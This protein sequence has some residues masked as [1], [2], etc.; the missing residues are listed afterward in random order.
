LAFT[1]QEKEKM[2]SR[3]TEWLDKSQAI[4]LLE[5]HGMRMKDM[6]TLRA[7]VRDAGGEVHVVKNT[8]LSRAMQ[9]AGIKY[10]E[11]VFDGP[12]AISF[13]YSD[14]PGLAKILS[15][16]TVKSEIFKI[17]GG[18]LGKQAM[19]AVDVKNLADLPPLPVMRARLL[20]VLQA[21]AAQVA[22]TIAEPARSL[23]AVIKAYSDKQ[24]AESTPAA[25]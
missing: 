11:K 7:K 20:G 1:K 10:D 8:L 13:V 9:N 12:V 18:F 16:A 22:R 14:P 15:D 17:K 3:Y 4:V 6:N 23:A 24:P 19:S 2:Q 25:V 5:F 21:P